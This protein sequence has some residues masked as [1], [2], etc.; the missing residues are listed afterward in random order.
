MKEFI[1]LVSKGANQRDFNGDKHG[2]WFFYCDGL[3]METMYHGIYHG[4]FM[5]FNEKA[6]LDMVGFEHNN[7]NEG[8]EIS[9]EY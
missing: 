5:Y 4:V 9:F 1:N 3:V 8:E 6:C 7:E 2:R